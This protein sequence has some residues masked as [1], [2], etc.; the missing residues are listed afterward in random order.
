MEAARAGQHGKGFAVVA[1][2]VRNLAAKSAEAAKRTAEI[3]DE[4]IHS[5]KM[6]AE[7]A[8]DTA[9][10]FREILEA[11]ERVTNLVV[12]INESAGEQASSMI[13][14]NQGIEQV[15]R[16]IQKNTAMAEQSAA[17]SEKLYGQAERLT[18]MVGNY[19]YRERLELLDVPAQIKLLESVDSYDMLCS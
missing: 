13:I 6:G 16:I 11:V 7:I 3:I 19:K 15:S 5:V 1:D 10:V 9:K 14:I 17:M 18:A 12:N 4:S 2:E 8:Q